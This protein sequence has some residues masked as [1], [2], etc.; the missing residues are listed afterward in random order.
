MDPF[1]STQAD[2]DSRPARPPDAGLREGQLCTALQFEFLGLKRVILWAL[3][4]KGAYIQGLELKGPGTF[5][6]R[7]PDQQI[8]R[9]ELGWVLGCGLFLQ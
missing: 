5:S 6:V 2:S 8:A 1:G 7:N 4:P 9:W 3:N